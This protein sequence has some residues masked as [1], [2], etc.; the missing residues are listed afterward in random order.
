MEE[1][2]QDGLEGNEYASFLAWVKNEYP[3]P[4]LMQH[5]DLQVDLS[6]MEPLLTAESLKEL[7]NEY[8]KVWNQFEYE[9]SDNQKFIHIYCLDHGEKLRRMD[10][11]DH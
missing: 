4:N 7:E 6:N 10:G 5:P 1:I 9:I 8:L 2:V 3:G 11:K